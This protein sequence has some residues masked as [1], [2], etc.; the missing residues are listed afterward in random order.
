MNTLCSRQKD[1]W[2]NR[3]FIMRRTTA[4]CWNVCCLIFVLPGAACISVRPP[5]VMRA[6]KIR[7][8]SSGFTSVLW[9]SKE[10]NKKVSYGFQWAALMMR[11]W[12]R[13]TKL[14]WLC[15]WKETAGMFNNDVF[16]SEGAPWRWNSSGWF[17][18]S[19]LCLF[20]SGWSGFVRSEGRASGVL[21]WS[22]NNSRCVVGPNASTLRCDCRTVNI[23]SWN[24]PTSH[25]V[26]IE[27]QYKFLSYTHHY[28][29][30]LCKKKKQH[31]PEGN[32]LSLIQTIHFE[33]ESGFWK[34]F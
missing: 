17:C 33:F 27:T 26:T 12:A 16:F 11:L 24:K 15:L 1:V 13:L 2:H 28:E 32:S 10:K 14:G 3:K 31:E 21:P 18:S 9:G 23:S 20:C 19:V 34:Y 6:S 8:W 4:F 5:V 7:M 25:L 22:P 29:E 30:F